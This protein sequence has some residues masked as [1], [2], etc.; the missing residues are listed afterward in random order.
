[1]YKLTSRRAI[2]VRVQFRVSAVNR[3]DLPLI[4]TRRALPM[5]LCWQ[6]SSERRQ[7]CRERPGKAGNITREALLS[8]DK[9]L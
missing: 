5:A 3:V 9:F 6:L 1:M 4:Y 2:D 7:G 8:V